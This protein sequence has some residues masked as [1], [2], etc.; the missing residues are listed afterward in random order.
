MSF[1]AD[2][3]LERPR[4]AFALGRSSGNAVQRN[5]VRRR[6]RAL[7]RE[8][9]D[10]VRPGRYLLGVRGSASQ[11]TYRRAQ[12]QLLELLKSAGALLGPEE[13]AP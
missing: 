6:L 7:L 2:T 9:A 8:H 5:R 10:R 1:A 13:G 11:V 3:E 4:V 12:A